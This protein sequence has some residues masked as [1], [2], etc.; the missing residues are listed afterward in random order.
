M[1]ELLRRNIMLKAGFARTDITPPLGLPIDG[2]YKDRNVEGVLDAL[3]ICC[4][5]LEC[6]GTK[7][8]IISIDNCG[9][10]ITDLFNG[11]RKNIEKVTGIPFDNIYIGATHT[12]TAPA[13]GEGFEGE[14]TKAYRGWVDG[15]MTEA[16][17]LAVEDLKEAKMGWGTGVAPNVSFIRRFRMKDGSVQTNPGINNPDIVAPI[18]NIDDKVYVVRFNRGNDDIVFVNFAN[19]PDVV[20]DSKVSADWPGFAR[21]SV[22]LALPGTKCL[23]LNG[24]QGDINHVNVHPKGGD[25]N[26]MHDDFDDVLRGYGHARY[27]GRVVCG[28]VMQAFDKVNYCDVPEIKAASRVIPIPSNM[29]TKEELELAYKYDELHQAGKDEEI[30]F[31]GM[32]LTT[33]VAESERMIRLKDGP[34]HFDLKLSAIKIGPVAMVGIPGE[35]FNGIGV[36]IKEQTKGYGLI[37]L[38]CITNGYMGYFPMKDAYDEGG[39]EARSS[40][41]RSGS[42]ELII[43][44]GKKLLEEIR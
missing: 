13:L 4:I 11:Y 34:D 15:K 5:A 24:A 27:I 7:T 37:M 10:N 12:H 21:R 23:V 44:E 1:P 42:A 36:G 20:G 30:P 19:H 35:P 31:K 9:V 26:D 17:I 25:A 6:D 16:V 29:P 41:F 3:E 22:E 18:G 40:V 32:M 2:Y 8:A 14:D 39:Y 28:G 43:E 33:V 38:T